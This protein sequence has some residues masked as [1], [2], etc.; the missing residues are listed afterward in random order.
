MGRTVSLGPLPV[1]G[2]MHTFERTGRARG[3]DSSAL[4]KT[5]RTPLAGVMSRSLYINYCM[6]ASLCDKALPP[7][8]LTS[9]SEKLLWKVAPLTSYASQ[10]FTSHGLQLLHHELA[11]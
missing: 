10:I 11:I 5:H 4:I 1:E 8:P 3:K 6:P 2:S 7:T 9:Q